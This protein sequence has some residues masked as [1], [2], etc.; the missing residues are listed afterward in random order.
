VLPRTTSYR[1]AN[2]AADH[3]YV[4]L[5]A[6]TATF[7]VSGGAVIADPKQLPAAQASLTVH[8]LPSLQ[9]VPSGAVG[10]EQLPVPGLHVPATWH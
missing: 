5:S 2:V 7:W 6:A 8:A 9:V 4:D 1:V 3:V 10:F